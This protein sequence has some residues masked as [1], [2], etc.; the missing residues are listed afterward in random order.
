MEEARRP[1]E[2][3]ARKMVQELVKAM[4]VRYEQLLRKLARRPVRK[5]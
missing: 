4:A 1:A 3:A 5:G 2:L